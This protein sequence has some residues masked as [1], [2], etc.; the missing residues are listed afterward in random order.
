[1][2]ASAI[3]REYCIQHASCREFLAVKRETAMAVTVSIL[4]HIAVAVIL[5]M[6]ASD[7][8]APVISERPRIIHVTWVDA[9]RFSDK[10]SLAVH[11]ETVKPPA[12]AV[13]QISNSHKEQPLPEKQTILSMQEEKKTT[14]LLNNIDQGPAPGA[15][16]QK[17]AA[18]Q[19]GRDSM[20]IVTLAHGLKTH[21]ADNAAANISMAK[22]RY[23][24]NAPPPYPLPARIRGYEGVVLI[25]A[26]I[27]TEGRAGNLKIKSSSGYSILDQ[28]ALEAV[29][30]WKFDPARKMGKPVSAWVDIPV[31]YVLKTSR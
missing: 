4:F 7:A 26:E 16:E 28:S 24:E 25:S 9:T 15:A 22:P 6:F 13:Q 19:T 29:K 10:N 21:G 12:A 2:P 11:S 14:L 1:M 3:P 31:R 18:T 8:L 5:Y 17:S 30:A 27:L 20:Q 23:R